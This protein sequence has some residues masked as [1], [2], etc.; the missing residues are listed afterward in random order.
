MLNSELKGFY[1]FCRKRAQKNMEISYE[2]DAFLKSAETFVKKIDAAKEKE[3]EWKMNKLREIEH[4]MQAINSLAP[5]EENEGVVIARYTCEH[6]LYSK[7]V[8]AESKATVLSKAVSDVE[9]SENLPES[10]RVKGTEIKAY[11]DE[12]KA[13]LQKVSNVIGEIAKMVS[14]YS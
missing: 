7:Y 3:F 4:H 12:I 11:V 8:E 2:F 6:V 5:T 14:G 1:P 9:I 13:H 10:L